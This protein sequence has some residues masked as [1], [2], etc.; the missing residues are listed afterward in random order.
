MEVLGLG[1]ESELK[2]PATAMWDPSHICDLY[3]NLQQHWILNPL[4][5]ARDWICILTDTVSGS[6]PA[7]PQWELQMRFFYLKEKNPTFLMVMLLIVW[8]K[9]SLETKEMARALFFSIYL[10]IYFAF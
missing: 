2:L 9:F 1:V 3:L 10:F 6:L 5:K 8:T 7:E 4:R